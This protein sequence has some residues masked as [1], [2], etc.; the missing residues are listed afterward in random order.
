MANDSDL[1]KLSDPELVAAYAENILTSQLPQSVADLNRLV[2][3]RV[4]IVAELQRRNPNLESLRGLLQHADPRVRAI[5]ANQLRR[6]SHATEFAGL[7]AAV[8]AF[9]DY[10]HELSP[11]E[12]RTFASTGHVEK[13]SAR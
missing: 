13:V 3:L 8:K 2:Q 7:V 9:A 10:A 11:E 4:S 6:P 1:L 12:R 5:T